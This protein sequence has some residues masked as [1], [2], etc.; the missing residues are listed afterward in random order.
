MSIKSEVVSLDILTKDENKHADMI[1]IMSTIQGYLGSDYNE[2]RRVLS[3]EGS[4][5]I[6]TT[7]RLPETH[8][9]WQHPKRMPPDTE[10]SSRRLALR[11]EPTWSKLFLSMHI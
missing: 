1:A 8:N 11:S 3:G 6:R 5:D 10:T 9:V 4:S 2:E 7:S